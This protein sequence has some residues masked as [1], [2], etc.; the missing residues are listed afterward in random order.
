MTWYYRYPSRIVELE[1]SN[2]SE[3]L[4]RSA[5]GAVKGTNMGYTQELNNYKEQQQ[6]DSAETL[7]TN[8][9]DQITDRREFQHHRQRLTSDNKLRCRRT[10]LI[11]NHFVTFSVQ[12][13]NSMLSYETQKK[14]ARTH[15][16]HV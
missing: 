2:S 14:Q 13:L 4:C 10:T 12:C 11:H 8:R 3:Q 6:N 1:L 7:C 9:A 5:V 16:R 15:I